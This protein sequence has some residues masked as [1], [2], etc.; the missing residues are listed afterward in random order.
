MIAMFFL[1]K[2]KLTE[3]RCVKYMENET[4]VNHFVN[5]ME[6]E[7]NESHNVRSIM[8]NENIIVQRTECW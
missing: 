4:E 7:T 8:E 5:Y 6:N 1:W 2:M 3:K